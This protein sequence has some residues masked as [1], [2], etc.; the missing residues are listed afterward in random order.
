MI[1]GIII[2]VEEVKVVEIA[3]LAKKNNFY[4]F[5]HIYLY[6]FAF[7]RPNIFIKL[8]LANAFKLLLTLIL[9]FKT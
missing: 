1:K 6:L 9:K 2:I 7:F 8:K 5:T 3:S 4:Q